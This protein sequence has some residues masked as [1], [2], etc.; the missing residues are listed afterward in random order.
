MATD[1]IARLAEQRRTWIPLADGR[2][3]VR[4]TRP[5]DTE[6]PGLAGKPLVDVVCQY[7][8]G[9]E[10]FTEA[11]ILGDAAGS[12]A[13]AEFSPELFSLWARDQVPVLTTLAEGLSQIV[14][15]RV[16]QQ[17]ATAKN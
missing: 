14:E 12:D 6:L 1:L 16:K 17:A 8:D 9:W 5:L 2:R 11:D 7:V 15:T 13:P 10:G 4:I 3:R